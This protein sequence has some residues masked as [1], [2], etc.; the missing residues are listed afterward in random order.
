MIESIPFLEQNSVL[1]KL[2]LLNPTVERKVREEIKKVLDGQV[3]RVRLNLGSDSIRRLNEWIQQNDLPLE[4]IRTGFKYPNGTEDIIV[5]RTGKGKIPTESKESTIESIN[6]LVGSLSTTQNVRETVRSALLKLVLGRDDSVTLNLNESNAS[7]IQEWAK[8][9]G[10]NTAIVRRYSNGTVDLLISTGEIQTS[11]HAASKNKIPKSSFELPRVLSSNWDNIYAGGLRWAYTYLSLYHSDNDSLLKFYNGL[12]ENDQIKFLAYLLGRFYSNYPK[13]ASQS[14][15]L[16][17]ENVREQFRKYISNLDMD[18]IIEQ[19]N[20]HLT[21][22]RKQANMVVEQIQQN[23]RARGANLEALIGEKGMR[24]LQESLEYMFFEF[25]FKDDDVERLAQGISYSNFSYVYDKLI[26]LRGKGYRHSPKKNISD[27]EL[28]RIAL[29]VIITDKFFGVDYRLLLAIIGQETNFDESAY[30]RSG[31][32]LTQQTR[33]GWIQYSIKLPTYYENYLKRVKG[34][35]VDYNVPMIHR[36]YLADFNTPNI[37]EGHTLLQVLAGALTII[38]K[39][40]EQG[41]S[42]VSNMKGRSKELHILG[43]AYN[44]HPDLDLRHNYGRGI[45]SSKFWEL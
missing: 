24:E 2:K 25:K 13:L 43:V 37:D 38:G 1:D 36:L 31:V 35:D 26:E 45:R 4:V 16:W 7:K 17:N 11:K 33:M 34:I 10:Y 21:R 3:D 19:F 5:R 9:N 32:G 20:T 18:V 23:F 29:S 6:S 42:N 39:A 27:Q 41:I 15:E 44:G 14:P 30:G 12:S 28:A 22:A 8:K 40:T